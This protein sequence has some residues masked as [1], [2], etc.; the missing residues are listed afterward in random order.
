MSFIKVIAGE[1]KYTVSIDSNDKRLADL[2]PK[3]R[4]KRAKLP[5]YFESIQFVLSDSDRKLLKL[6]KCNLD[7][8]CE[9]SKLSDVG[10]IMLVKKRFAD[11]GSDE[12]DTEKSERRRHSY[13]E[14]RLARKETPSDALGAKSY[15]FNTVTAAEYKSW[16]VTKKNKWGMWQ[17]R[18]LGVSLTQITNN[19][20]ENTGTDDRSK[21]VKRGH[22]NIS[23][24]K[25]VVLNSVD[26]MKEVVKIS[27]G[28]FRLSITTILL[29]QM[30]RL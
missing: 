25:R 12:L 22:R 1:Q 10:S 16:I 23:D 11:M 8:S 26:G 7:L 19:K 28:Y 4:A 9:L 29:R 6:S 13:F 24:V 17:K 18:A 15:I 30:E 2:I 20:V 5:L 3:L 27:V 21:D 14:P